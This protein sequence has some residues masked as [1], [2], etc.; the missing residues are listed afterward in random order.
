MQARDAGPALVDW[1]RALWRRVAGVLDRTAPESLAI[2]PQG[3]DSACAGRPV[4]MI[5]GV[6]EPWQFLLPLARSLRAAGHPVYV[7]PA[8]GWNLRPIEPSVRA[9]ADVVIAHDLQNVTLVGHSKGGLIARSA[10]RDPALA[11]RLAGAITTCTPWHGTALV[12]NWA[13]RTPFG[14]FRPQARAAGSDRIVSLIPRFDQVVT[15]G[16]HLDEATNIQLGVGG[17]FGPT[18]DPGV[19]RLVHRW[20]HRL[21]SAH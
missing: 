4:V 5:P 15:E 19:H 21:S 10:L 11:P 8:L 7:L 20:V 2:V 17:H 3:A 1:G 12:P 16:S 13:E 6:L 14:M 18:L 9:V